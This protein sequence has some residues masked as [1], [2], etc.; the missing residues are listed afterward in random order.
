M[1]GIEPFPDFDN[2]DA[3]SPKEEPEG[4]IYGAAGTPEHGVYSPFGQDEPVSYD[5]DDDE[6]MEV[7]A[8]DDF[9]EESLALGP[10]EDHDGDAPGPSAAEDEPD[11]VEEPAS[12]FGSDDVEA[13]LGAGAAP[14]VGA[15]DFGPVTVDA[16]DPDDADETAPALKNR[17]AE[18]ARIASADE[19]FNEEFFG[20][21][22]ASDFLGLDLEFDPSSEAVGVEASG[23]LDFVALAGVSATSVDESDPNADPALE[24]EG[25][26]AEAE[27]FEDEDYLSDDVGDV[28][29]VEPEDFFGEEELVPAG[30]SRRRMGLMLGGGFCVGLAAVVL[31]IVVP[32]YLTETPPEPVEVA[33]GSVTPPPVQPTV[34]TH[35]ETP[36]ST[37]P[38]F[39]PTRV[40]DPRLLVPQLMHVAMNADALTPK[41][42]DLVVVADP[43]VPSDSQPNVTSG[44]PDV[45]PL[46]GDPVVPP[47]VPD[48]L[49]DREQRSTQLRFEDLVLDR[50]DPNSFFIE[51]LGELD[52]VWRGKFVPLDA[53]KTPA[54]VLTPSVG[55]VRV[56]MV[57]GAIFEGRLFAI[58]QNKIWLDVDLG[59]LG[60]DGTR[61]K[62]VEHLDDNSV[63][64]IDPGELA[65]GKRVRAQVP[66]G[67]IYGRVRSV[68]GKRVT[69]VTDQGARITLEDPVLETVGK[70]RSVAVKGFARAD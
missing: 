16:A 33:G 46:G 51:N 68:D 13:E 41:G 21:E 30:A 44:E 2:D 7:F 23:E 35:V 39:G 50:A 20:S 27:G 64:P 54:K 40:V 5:S 42:P 15:D 48:M 47:E 52:V 31:A 63:D 24:P 45:T 18:G 67:V 22:G 6:P 4:D 62:R 38:G 19:V 57:S 59:R 70:S 53:L 14:E 34:V 37:V 1:S 8:E 26:Y 17:P 25:D 66:G 3:T 12:P 56:H 65:T 32:R 11:P 60:L 43:V 49:Y 55:D 9:P 61:V 28:A 58:G 29:G 10:D 69:L 36:V